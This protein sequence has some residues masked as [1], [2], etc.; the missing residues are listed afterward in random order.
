MLEAAGVLRVRRWTEGVDG[1]IAERRVFV[2]DEEAAVLYGRFSLRMPPGQ[3]IERAPRD[4]RYIVPVI[5]RGQAD[6][7]RELVN[8]IDRAA[9]IAARY[10][11]RARHPGQ[12]LFQHLD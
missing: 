5:P 10:H 8:A 12:R 6:L 11:E 2:I 7:L 4:R 3:H 9:R 1:P